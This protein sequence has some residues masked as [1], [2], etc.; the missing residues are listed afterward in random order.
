MT[1]KKAGK[2]AYQPRGIDSIAYVVCQAANGRGACRCAIRSE[3][4]CETME[5]RAVWVVQSVFHREDELKR[6]VGHAPEKGR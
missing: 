2:P 5:Q 4:P 1:A 6:Y 3:R